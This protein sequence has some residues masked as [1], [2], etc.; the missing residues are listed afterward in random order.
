MERLQK[1]LAAAG[2]GSRRACE[3]LIAAGRVS[4]N[5]VTVDRMGVRV[6]PATDL[7]EV[8]GI[9]IDIQEDKLYLILNKPAAYVTTASD[10]QGRPTVMELVPSGRRIF[11][12]GR[13][14]MDTRGLLLFTNDGWLANRVAHPSFELD[15]TY[16]AE[17]TGELAPGALARLRGGIELED[18]QTSPA[19]V[20]VLGRRAGITAIELKIHEGRKRQVRR[21]LAAVGLEVTGLTRTSLGPLN[22]KGL[23]EGKSRE[24]RPGELKALMRA[25]GL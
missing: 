7:I 18:G 8:D 13:L 14:D 24:L 21:M 11:P 23:P 1:V 6:D 2:L 16:V 20:R 12:V 4:V 5:G 19:Q 17:V 10:P 25:L 22:L 9:R 3:E 15:K